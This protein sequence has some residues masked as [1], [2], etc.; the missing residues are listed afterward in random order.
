MMSSSSVVKKKV[1]AMSVS[2]TEAFPTV[3]LALL[4]EVPTALATI[5]GPMVG[6]EC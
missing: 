4:V 5:P 3:G 2:S 6:E 1:I